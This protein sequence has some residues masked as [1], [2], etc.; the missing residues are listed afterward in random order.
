MARDANR[1]P[2][3]VTSQHRS[4]AVSL[5]GG[6]NFPR[7]SFDGDAG[8]FSL[9]DE[10]KASLTKGSDWVSHSA[11]GFA[12]LPMVWNSILLAE[13]DYVS[14][15][16]AWLSL[17]AIPGSVIKQV[18]SN[19]LH[20]VL[21]TSQHGVLV[22]NVSFVSCPG[23]LVLR[24]DAPEG[25]RPWSQILISDL[26]EWQAVA[27][28]GV[29]PPPPSKAAEYIVAAGLGAE[30]LRTGHRARES[31]VVARLR[32]QAGVLHTDLPLAREAVHIDWCLCQEAVGRD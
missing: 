11:P 9:G 5:G 31:G 21:A 14:L 16:R 23:G 27:V 20:Y 8:T 29:S 13:G 22:W 7:S 15:G 1:G 26:S 30:V 32:R 6:R 12:L 28:D 18:Q 10:A 24:W 3:P 2:A 17:L 25:K 4:E 19:T